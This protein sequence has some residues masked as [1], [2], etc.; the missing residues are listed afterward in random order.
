MVLCEGMRPRGLFL[1]NLHIHLCPPS[2]HS[3]LNGHI[4]DIIQVWLLRFLEDSNSQILWLLQSSIHYSSM[5]P[6]TDMHRC[7]MHTIVKSALQVEKPGSTHEAK[8][9]METHLL[10]LWRSHYSYTHTISLH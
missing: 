4:G 3:G 6:L 9:F 1:I 8:S 10:E 2:F 5:F 7:A